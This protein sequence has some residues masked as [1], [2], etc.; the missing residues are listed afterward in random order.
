ME[1]NTAGEIRRT[2]SGKWGVALLLLV[3]V[4]L[5]LVAG[6]SLVSRVG[7][8]SRAVR[9]ELTP[10][11]N[12]VVR[13]VAAGDTG[14]LTALTDPAA[15]PTWRETFL[16]APDVFVPPFDGPVEV[17]QVRSVEGTDIVQATV[18][19]PWDFEGLSLTVHQLL[20]VRRVAGRWRLTFP[21]LAEHF[22]EPRT[23]ALDRV[24]LTLHEKE[25]RTVTPAL[26]DL[27]R[28]IADLEAVAPGERVPPVRLTVELFGPPGGW[29]STASSTGLMLRVQ[30][31]S[32]AWW[33]I[34]PTIDLRARAA[35]ALLQ[36]L[37]ATSPQRRAARVAVAR[38]WAGE[39]HQVHPLFDVPIVGAVASL[40]D[41]GRWPTLEETFVGRLEGYSE[42]EQQ[43]VWTTAYLWLLTRG[44]PPDEWPALERV[45]DREALARL[46]E[47]WLEMS[48]E[49][50]EGEWRNITLLTS[51]PSETQTSSSPPG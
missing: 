45:R 21:P 36:G 12:E 22:G 28:L 23:L 15:D 1:T 6:F 17:R 46:V 2:S 38:A 13:L 16:R 48:L 51:S 31:P 24:E 9:G 43:A 20:Y 5:S 19:G 18:V 40:V 49:E 32:V 8:Q 41:E 47:G 26:T 14:G 34:E 50:A 25:N 7:R 30:S 33:T 11:A 35:W 42:A 29:S 39:I 37:P 10:L 44:V 3:V 4:V 27:P